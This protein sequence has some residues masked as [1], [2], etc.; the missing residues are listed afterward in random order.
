MTGDF[1]L[2]NWY[3]SEDAKGIVQVGVEYNIY[4]KVRHTSD[5]RRTGSREDYFAAAS[6]PTGTA[7]SV[8]EQR[9][10]WTFSE[11]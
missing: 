7:E 10:L 11:Q 9:S 6:K 8:S 1:E 4:V 2:H 3:V 5:K